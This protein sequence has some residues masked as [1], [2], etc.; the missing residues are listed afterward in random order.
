MHESVLR[1]H[2]FANQ[3]CAFVWV[4]F[5]FGLK[6]TFI[7]QWFFHKLKPSKAQGVQKNGSKIEQKIIIA[8]D[9]CA[10]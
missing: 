6:E 10:D 7:L 4:E 3:F 9:A 5:L 1:I 8:R 2:A